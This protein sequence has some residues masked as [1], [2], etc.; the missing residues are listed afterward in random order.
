MLTG[1][2]TS[3]DKFKRWKHQPDE[4]FNEQ[5]KVLM[6]VLHKETNN[7]RK[8]T[9]FQLKVVNQWNPESQN[10]L[11]LIILPVSLR[12]KIRT[13]GYSMA[14]IENL[15]MDGLLSHI[16][17][18]NYMEYWELCDGWETKVVYL[19][20][21]GL[22]LDR[23]RSFQKKLVKLPYS[24]RSVFK[25]SIIFQKALTWVVDISGPLHIAFHMLQ[26]ILSYTKVR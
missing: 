23:H 24:Y 14:I 5:R 20:M 10:A 13:N 22:S 19:C 1:Y 21:D 8:F 16:K 3:Q 2:V 12:D 7:L 9:A 25:Q 26:S 15:Y 18:K 6:K 11:F 17:S 4:Y